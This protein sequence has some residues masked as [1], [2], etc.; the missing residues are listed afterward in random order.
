MTIYED[1]IDLRPYV[2]TI[3]EHWWQIALVAGV[4]ALAALGSSLLQPRMYEAA[5]TIIVTRSQLILS[6]ADQFPT[7]TDTTDARRMDAFLVIAKSDSIDQATMDTLR[8]V[9]PSEYD[10]IED[11]KESVDITNKGDA[12]IVIATSKDPNLAVDIANVW[13][14]ET[15]QAINLAYSGAQP[16]EEIR[17]QIE[18][19]ETS[20]KSAQAALENFIQNNQIIVLETKIEEAKTILDDLSTD[21]TWLMSY[22]T[23]RSQEMETLIIQ[24]GTL[25]QQLESG[26]RSAA[27]DLG[28]ALA[29][30]TARSA[31]LGTQ[32]E[33]VFELHLAD[34]TTLRD[35]KSNYV[36][37][38]AAII[39]QANTAKIEAETAQEN[40]AQELSQGEGYELTE[41]IAAQIRELETQLEGEN[42]HQLEL[43][44]ERDLAWN[45]YQALM[46]KETEIQTAAQ[47]NTEVTLASPAITPQMPTARQTIVKTLIGG[48][49]GM[50]LGVFWVFGAKWW[51]SS[52]LSKT[53][54]A[55]TQDEG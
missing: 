42:A 23:Q 54:I 11:I 18:S 9:L 21:R 49:L 36:S 3:L 25:E 45:A 55:P 12:I 8:D 13:A 48:T 15:T 6:L 32:M 16:L 39:Q 52:D 41:T 20:Y 43:T 33:P 40:L 29:V 2:L 7:V 46:Q 14:Q 4:L 30:L 17:A 1:E 44:S 22:Y 5:A 51:Q 47:T 31:A 38:L 26:T 37:D 50:M 35:S 10:N 53:Q 24:L 19:T 34:I 28:D 27:G